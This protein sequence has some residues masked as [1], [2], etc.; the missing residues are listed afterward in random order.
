[1]GLCGS[2]RETRV[3]AVDALAMLGTDH[4]IDPL[5]EVFGH[6]PSMTVRERAGCS[7]AEC[8]MPTR[9]QRRKTL[10]GLIRL[11][12]DPTLDKKTQNWAFQALT[13]ISGQHFGDVRAAW[14]DWYA[15][16]L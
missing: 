3:W 16:N 5:L 6:D 13:E 2:H 14:H 7:L 12:D 11:T 10:P 1:V 9:E 4:I 15:R 8:G